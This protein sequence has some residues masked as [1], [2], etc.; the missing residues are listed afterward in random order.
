[1]D[2]LSQPPLNRQIRDLEQELEI[3]LFERSAKAIRLNPA[4][5]I[6]LLEARA[7]LQRADDAVAFT[8][9]VTHRK[10]SQIRIG[11][12]ESP[13]AEILPRALRAEKSF[14]SNPAA[15]GTTRWNTRIDHV[16]RRWIE[17]SDDNNPRPGHQHQYPRIQNASSTSGRG[18][19]RRLSEDVSNS[20]R[21]I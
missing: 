21:M 10:R 14:I 20:L 5:R 11:H 16:D 9:A 12:S 15:P 13:A 8:K 6:F 19:R 2:N 7:V 4:G 3:T 18:W 17:T 1:M